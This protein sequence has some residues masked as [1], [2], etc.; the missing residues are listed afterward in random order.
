M[1]SYL[2]AGAVVQ[3]APVSKDRVVATP[4]QSGQTLSMLATPAKH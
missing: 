2:I 4:P 3:F 1:T